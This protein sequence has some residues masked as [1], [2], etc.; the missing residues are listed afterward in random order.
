MIAVTAVGR[1]A[2]ANVR[3]LNNGTVA[4]PMSNAEGLGIS[5]FFGG[6]GTFNG[7]V[8]N[9]VIENIDQ[10]ANPA[11]SSGIGVQSD[12][13][14]NTGANTDV[15]NSNFTVSNNRSPTLAG[16]GII[17]TGINNAGT[18]N[19]RIIDNNVT[20]VP[21]LAARF[22]IRVQHSN[23]GTQPTI[24]LEMHGNDT[25]GGN[26]VIGP[27]DGIGIRQQ[28][29]LHVLHR[30]VEP[31]AGQRHAGGDLRQ[32]TERRGDHDGAR[33]QQLHQLQRA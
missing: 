7:L 14:G 16:N 6:N 10:A 4:D 23:V 15:T 5:L 18:M 1:T 22:G 3:I 17:A 26:P 9:N 24:N 21:D 29:P 13:G 31:V 28:N 32:R 27:P 30:R 19:I 2:S 12:F 11:G 8:H 25:A 20:T 33:R